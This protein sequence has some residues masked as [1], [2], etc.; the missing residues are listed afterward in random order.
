ML[1]GNSSSVS[2]VAKY[3]SKY[4]NFKQYSFEDNLINVISKRLNIQKYHFEPEERNKINNYDKYKRTYWQ[5]L[6]DELEIILETDETI[7][8]K[9]VIKQI[10]EENIKRILI[11]DFSHNYELQTI[12]KYFPDSIIIPITIKK[13]SIY[14]LITCSNDYFKLYDNKDLDNDIQKFMNTLHEDIKYLYA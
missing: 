11:T 8:I 14:D 5:I 6:I 9:L 13:N 7:L 3:I 2:K 12:S 10:L 1:C 4:Y